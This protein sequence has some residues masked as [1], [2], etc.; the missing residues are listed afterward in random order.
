MNKIKE[1]RFRS[2]GRDFRVILTPNRDVLHSRFKAYAV[3]GDGKETSVHLDHENFYNGRVFGEVKSGAR[4]HIEDG[5]I[6]GTIH[7]E[8][9]TYHI[10]PSWRHLPNLGNR[11]MIAYKASDVKFSWDEAH[12]EPGSPGPRTCGYVKEGSEL[13]GDD[14]DEEGAEEKIEEGADRW[15]REHSQRRVKRQL[16]Q[17]EYTPTKT[18]CPLLLVADYR[19]FQEMGGSNTKTTINYLVRGIL[20]F[21]FNL[22]DYEFQ[23]FNSI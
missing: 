18:R 1:V 3:D 9:E 15:T 6:T 21:Q 14:E 11:S 12:S 20:F 4:L 23:Y 19:F 5:V 22:T 8:D 10:E 2:H 17:Y 7:I 13:E 16:D